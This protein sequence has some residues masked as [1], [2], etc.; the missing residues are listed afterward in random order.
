[1]RLFG[2]IRGTAIAKEAPPTCHQQ[3]RSRDHRIVKPITR[4]RQPG[5]RPTGRCR[6]GAARPCQSHFPNTGSVWK[7]RIDSSLARVEPTTCRVAIHFSHQSLRSLRPV[8]SAV[9]RLSAPSAP[10]C[11]V[12]LGGCVERFGPLPTC[13]VPPERRLVTAPGCP[14]TNTGGAAGGRRSV[15]TPTSSRRDG[16][17]PTARAGRSRRRAPIPGAH[18]PCAYYMSFRNS[19][20]N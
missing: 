16:R 17:C 3:A 14:A 18:T 12:G 10:L 4:R 7:V 5:R 9:P 13:R 11:R 2:D 8:G 15:S 19:P 1:L 6:Y 20:A